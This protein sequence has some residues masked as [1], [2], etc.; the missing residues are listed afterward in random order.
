[1]NFEIRDTSYKLRSGY[2]SP[3]TPADDSTLPYLDCGLIV[4]CRTVPYIDINQLS[5]ADLRRLVIVRYSCYTVRS[6]G[7]NKISKFLY[8]DCRLQDCVTSTGKFN[9]T[10][11]KKLKLVFYSLHCG[12]PLKWKNNYWRQ[13]S[14]SVQI[15]RA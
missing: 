15:V 3:P 8:G 6:A 10:V 12:V 1:M 5:A 9:L 7:E 11:V 4:R 13:D 2:E 14:L